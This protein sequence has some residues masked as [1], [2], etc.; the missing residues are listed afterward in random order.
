MLED[1][2]VRG[3]GTPDDQRPVIFTGPQFNAT[4]TY[5]SDPIA[6]K[7]AFADA[8]DSQ[9]EMIS[10]EE[11][12]YDV[13]ETEAK[14]AMVRLLR[15]VDGGVP[16]SISTSPF[17]IPADTTVRTGYTQEGI[18]QYETIPGEWMNVPGIDSAQ[19]NVSCYR[20]QVQVNFQFRRYQ[21]DA[22]KGF[23][24]Y[25]R[26]EL[27]TN[28]IYRGQVI[29]TGHEYVDVSKVDRDKMVYSE[30]A[31]N[32]LHTWAIGSIVDAD[33]MYRAGMRT[34]VSV[35]LEGPAG[36]GKTMFML[37][38]QNELF[39]RGSDGFGAVIV[40]PGATIEQ[41]EAGVKL[42]RRLAKASGGV[43]GLFTE[44]IEKMCENKMWRSRMLEAVDGAA[45]KNDRIL[46]MATT[47][48]KHKL[49]PALLRTGRCDALIHVG[50]PDQAAFQK[51]CELHLGDRLADIDWDEAFPHFHD[52]TPSWIVNSTEAVVRGVVARTHTAD[53]ITVT[54]QDLI[55]AAQG[56]RPQF[57]AQQ[58]AENYVEPLPTYDQVVRQTIADEVEAA[59]EAGQTDMTDYSAIQEAA[60]NAIENR[61]DGANIGW[62]DPKTGED[63]EGR[64]YTN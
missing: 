15:A 28:S 33:E 43:I 62:T 52:Y 44:D 61:I 29:T 57:E 19:V 26:D 42:A 23:L 3:G 56:Y 11:V 31:F 2:I 13:T 47:N 40:E 32:L 50:M 20:N 27:A 14:V 10:N 51:L 54:T 9:F 35:F 53:N 48:F 24:A 30:E 55:M 63:V 36:T 49:D 16:Q 41:F 22:I 38:T 60:D 4:S 5:A 7:A 25:M 64:F 39:K 21:G 46:L 8:I 18:M 12:L 45:G 6:S 17:K 1:L 58:A 37:L 34:K 59:V